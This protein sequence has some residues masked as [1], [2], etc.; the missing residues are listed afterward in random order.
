M[1]VGEV[2]GDLLRKADPQGRRFSARVV[3][4]WHD[5]CGEVVS[6]HT[7]GV[8]FREGQLVVSVDSPAWASE[9]SVLS[10]TFR[11]ALATHLGQD[12]VRSIRFT[13]SKHV[14]SERAREAAESRVGEY[15]KTDAVTPVP[16]TEIEREQA[17][18]VS[19]AVPDAQLREIALRVMVKDLEWKKAAR[20]RSSAQAP[21]GG[22]SGP[23]L[24]V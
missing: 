16:L 9:L 15:Y 3:A 23:D 24:T 7:R 21:P 17:A 5:V 2:A 18:Y 20:E 13:V 12:L 6:N 22:V 1:S 19:Q 14:Q 8:A 11:T 10:D 4:A